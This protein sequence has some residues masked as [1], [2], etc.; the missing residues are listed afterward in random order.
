MESAQATETLHDGAVVTLLKASSVPRRKA[1][2]AMRG[3]GGE[4]DAL[5]LE[6]AKVGDE[7]R[8]GTRRGR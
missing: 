3:L 2:A 1:L 4:V 7:Q 8:G 6:I 5:V